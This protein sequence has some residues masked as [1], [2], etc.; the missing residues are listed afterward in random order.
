MT[1]I[2]TFGLLYIVGGFVL[3]SRSPE[4]REFA[5]LFPPIDLFLAIALFYH[6]LLNFVEEVPRDVCCGKEFN[7]AQVD[8]RRSDASG[9]RSDSGVRLRE[10]RSG[11]Y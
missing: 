11:P 2:A 7:S 3:V 6:S 8:L 4:P 9:R 5:H 10:E 1:P